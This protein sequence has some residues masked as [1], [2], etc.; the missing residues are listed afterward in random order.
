[1]PFVRGIGPLELIIVLVIVMMIFGV[2]QLPQVGQAMGKA[3]REF[4]KSQ[5]SDVDSQDVDS[6]IGTT[7][8]SS[9]SGDE[10]SAPK[11][12]LFSCDSV[13]LSAK[14]TCTLDYR[15]FSQVERDIN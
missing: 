10:N 2:G 13:A 15:V 7:N 12:D 8:E 9:S 3:M 14:S 11:T 4:R 5:N 1:M 6:M